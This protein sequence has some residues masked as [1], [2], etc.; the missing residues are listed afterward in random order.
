MPYADREKQLDYM[1]I[2]MRHKRALNR[3]DRLKQ[4]KQT[5]TQ[6]YEEEPYLQHILPKAEASGHIDRQIEAC[7]KT[8][9]QYDGL[10]QNPSEMSNLEGGEG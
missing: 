5:L 6:Q 2:Y 9:K 1:R 4:R 7:M 3:I 10:L 8:I